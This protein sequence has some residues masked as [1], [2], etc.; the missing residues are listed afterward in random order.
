MSSPGA[1]H[2]RGGELLVLVVGGG[3][4]S[5]LRAQQGIFPGGEI[6]EFE[7]PVVT[8]DHG[9]QVLRVLD[10]A[11]RDTRAGKW[12]AFASAENGAGNAETAGALLQALELAF[13]R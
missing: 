9:N 2:D 8:G 11:Q 5:T 1:G 13:A 6:C 7:V 10:V 4:V 12:I 3:D